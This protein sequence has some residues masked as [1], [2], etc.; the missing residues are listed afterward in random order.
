MYSDDPTIQA[1]HA[2]IANPHAAVSAVAA[3][4][5][6]RAPKRITARRAA[7]LRTSLYKAMGALESITDEINELTDGKT[8][9]VATRLDSLG[10]V[11]TEVHPGLGEALAE[12]D[13]LVAELEADG[14]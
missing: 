6:R 5:P 9:A 12:L 1:A 8:G 14:L 3:V 13:T 2:A 10:G 4:A 7:T 11:L